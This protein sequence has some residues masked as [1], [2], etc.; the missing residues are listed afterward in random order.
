MSYPLTTRQR[1]PQT[2]Q[3]FGS[4]AIQHP[5]L[6]LSQAVPQIESQN[7]PPLPC[8]SVMASSASAAQGTTSASNDSTSSSQIWSKDTFFA[9][10]AE[11]IEHV[12]RSW[13]ILGYCGFYPKSSNPLE[14]LLTQSDGIRSL[15][16]FP[17]VV[18]HAPTLLCRCVFII[19][20]DIDPQWEI[21]TGH[22][23]WPWGAQPAIRMEDPK[24]N[25]TSPKM[26]GDLASNTGGSL[27]VGPPIDKERP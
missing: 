21:S 1:R 8:T 18:C 17:Q 25:E 6:L 26:A 9:Y 20:R 19:D 14:P 12:L 4:V 2:S 23:H 3:I 7:T 15:Y 24:P 22:L 11:R 10:P 27:R 13:V 5:P 16:K